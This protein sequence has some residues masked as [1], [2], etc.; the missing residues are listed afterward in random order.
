[1]HWF[2]NR[3]NDEH[4]QWSIQLIGACNEQ[5]ISLY[6]FSKTLIQIEVWGK[7]WAK[8]SLRWSYV[9]KGMLIMRI[10]RESEIRKRKNDNRRTQSGFGS[11]CHIRMLSVC[12]QEPY[13]KLPNRFRCFFSNTEKLKIFKIISKNYF[14]RSII[15]SEEIP[16]NSSNWPLTCDISVKSPAA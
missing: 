7:L 11:L 12:C 16:I 8:Q 13:W 9:S 4:E 15:F 2:Q 5:L 6:L 3:K 10:D 14:N 1:M